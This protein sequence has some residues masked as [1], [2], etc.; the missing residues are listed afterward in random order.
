MK[1][2]ETDDRFQ[3]TDLFKY[4]LLLL[5]ELAKSNDEDGKHDRLLNGGLH[6]L[7]RFNSISN[8]AHE[9]LNSLNETLL[10][11]LNTR[12]LNEVKIST[13]KSSAE[14]MMILLDPKHAFLTPLKELLGQCLGQLK[15]SDVQ[16]AEYRAKIYFIQSVIFKLENYPIQAIDSIHQAVLSHPFDSVMFGITIFLN[17]SNFHATIRQTLIDDLRNKPLNFVDVNPPTQVRGDLN[18]LQRAERL[19]LMKKY[20]RAIIKRLA[21]KDPVQAAYSYLDFIMCVRGNPSV[22]PLS[23]ILACVYFYK[24]MNH[25]Q[26]K[27]AELYAYRSIIFDLSVQIFLYVRHYL[28]VY[29]QM[30]IYKLLFTIIGRSSELF[31]KKIAAFERSTRS[32]T[33]SIIQDSHE[34][35][36]E[37]LVKNILQ[38]SRVNPL[39]H[40][41]SVST[42][43]D[44]AYMECAGNELLGRYFQSN[45]RTSSLYQYYYFEGVWKGWIDERNFL[46]E[47]EKCMQ[48]LLNDQRWTTNEVED[49]LSWSLI[50]KTND[51]WLLNSK[52]RLQFDQAVYSQVIGVS[53]NDDNGSI[54][55]MFT[56]AKKNEHSLFD[57]TDVLD[58]MTNGIVFA[59]FTLD[60]PNA[61]YHSHP[62][63]EMR[64]LP[65]RLSKIPN[66]LFTL[67]HADYL[68]KMISTGVEI[69]SQQPFPMRP[70]TENLMQRLPAY[71]REELQAIAMTKSGLITDSIHRFWIQPESTV[72]YEHAFYKGFFGRK[73]EKISQFYLSD[74]LKMCV[75]QHRMKFD[76]TGRLVD[77]ERENNDDQSAEAQFARIFTKYYDEIGKYFPELLR[78]KELVKLGVISR[79]IQGRYESEREFVHRIETN[80][81]LEEFLM[82]LKQRFGQYFG[83]ANDSD[84][85]ILNAC[86]KPLCKEFFCSKS[87]LKPHLI[88]F[89]KYN[90]TQPVLQFLRQSLIEQKAKLKFT[91]EKFRFYHDDSAEDEETM[92]NEES[93]CSW[94][95]AAFSSDSHIRVYGGVVTVAD[96]TSKDGIRDMQEKSKSITR[97]GPE[98]LVATAE[99]KAK[100][101]HNNQ[102]AG[103]GELL[104]CCEGGYFIRSALLHHLS[105]KYF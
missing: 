52:H 100:Q 5:N 37:E 53:L 80:P 105:I 43:H 67:F 88:N 75:K 30:Y 62:F 103:K 93:M 24:A 49:I 70:S 33:Q 89:F 46:H 39:T 27:S 7:F 97:V 59:F 87:N 92:S 68:L 101:R 83:I 57:A 16:P 3:V 19:I 86:C 26:C 99:K 56:Q 12:I 13:Y 58:V 14:C 41:S 35:L 6:S 102:N 22:Y 84:Q 28:S 73:N 61:E 50:P 44:M 38:I 9:N 4:H 60:P 40:L 72:E 91:I 63:H 15:I 74:D 20:E 66:Y 32:E 85:K 51:G 23:S 76:E 29:V 98:Q 81:A 64:Y 1:M 11:K 21:D 54:E 36:L 95:P 2:Y 18:F 8:E 69:C 82:M 71:I 77:D 48:D 78:L 25:P 104:S 34:L 42:I 47:R 31:A 94:V 96:M 90:R 79:I 65:K 10:N 45:A 17:R 55:F